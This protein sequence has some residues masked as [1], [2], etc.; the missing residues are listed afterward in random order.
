MRLRYLLRHVLVVIK[1]MLSR[2]IRIIIT[3]LYIGFLGIIT[4]P[5]YAQ[6]LGVDQVHN[7]GKQAGFEYA[8]ETSFSQNIGRI[9]TTLFSI[10]GVLF[11]VLI[12]YAGYLWMTAR[13]D[14]EQVSKAKSIISQAV[15]GLIVLLMAYS[16]TSFVIPRVLQGT[17]QQDATTQ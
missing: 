10:L 1:N 15:I 5:A 3:T 6:N 14:D 8:T 9:I 16:I 7:A 13:G 4:S 12:V 11:T 17:V 2:N